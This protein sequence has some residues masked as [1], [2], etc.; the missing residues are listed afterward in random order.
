V[1]FVLKDTFVQVACHAD[2]ESSRQ[3]AHDVRAVRFSLVRHR[4]E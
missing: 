4:R 3:A 1:E 2:V